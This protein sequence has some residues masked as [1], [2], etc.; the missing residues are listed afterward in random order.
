MKQRITYIVHDPESFNP[1]SLIVKGDTFSINGAD[2]AKEHRITFSLSELPQE[3]TKY[4]D[5]C[6]EL[7]IRW[8]SERPYAPIAPFVARVSPGFHAF[9]TP[10]KTGDT[11]ICPLLRTFD[12]N[13][14]CESPEHDF[15][16][17][18]VLSERFSMSSSL[19]FYSLLP[20]LKHFVQYL[21]YRVI[22]PPLDG[23]HEYS[24]ECM[25]PNAASSPLSP[26]LSASYLDMDYD[27]ISH[28]L[29]ISAFWAREPMDGSW[30]E[31]ITLN[32][33]GG[34]I[35]IGVLSNENNP[36]PEDL[37][38]SGFLTVL[39]QDDEPKPT[40]FQTPSRHHPLPPTNELTFTTGFSYPA[41][42]HPT[43]ELT[44]SSPAYAPI[45]PPNP[46]CK[47]HTHIT[48]PSS[49][50]IDKYQFSDPLFLQSH[51]LKS[52]RSIS[53]ATDLEAPEWVISQWGSAALFELSFPSESSQT[54]SPQS[55]LEGSS[56]T[57]FTVS[58]PLHTRYLPPSKVGGADSARVTVPYPVVFWACHT[59]SGTKQSASPFDRVHLGYEAL[60]GP[61]TMF[62][63]VPPAARD[64]PTLKLKG[65][66]KKFGG[67][68]SR[69]VAELNVP[70]LETKNAAVVEWGT[71]GVVVAA[72]LGL[73]WV[74][75][76]G[77]S[78][79]GKAVKSMKGKGKLED[80]VQGRE[81]KNE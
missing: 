81:K 68:Q 13:F 52:L 75:F 22:C 77:N 42:L 44:L 67:G 12:E 64:A 8:V 18:P 7:H 48:L 20:D 46:T 38:F 11:N 62:V 9:F 6:H 59:D 1:T 57:N 15:T 51:N 33:K 47:L 36:D 72:F 21:H 25:I 29:T 69:L 66:P 39:G 17:M 40:H 23:L 19:Q 34:S 71:V 16:V 24:S 80:V 10:L 32:S 70:V 74:L 45:A 26:L 73:C 78:P 54:S 37:A 3:I 27:A 14:L 65:G 55:P 61:K 50:F 35:E 49:L 76:R 41:G 56:N 60:F 63:H 58:I 2:A 43:L 79:D 28:A 31:T 5:R 30:T 53:G 4:L